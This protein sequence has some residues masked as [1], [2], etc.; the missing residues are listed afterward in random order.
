MDDKWNLLF[1]NIFITRKKV[2]IKQKNIAVKAIW[3]FV[4]KWYTEPRFSCANGI[5]AP[6]NDF[7]FLKQLQVYE[8]DNERIAEK[9]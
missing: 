1:K 2:Q 9:V 6:L 7:R 3:S 8:K 4:I 5:Q